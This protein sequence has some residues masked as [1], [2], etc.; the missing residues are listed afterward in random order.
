MRL[1][2]ELFTKR[3]FYGVARLTASLRRQGHSVNPKRVRR[4]MR[5]MG[6]EAIYPRPRLSANGSDHKVYP[7]L[8]KDVTVDRPDFAWA[9]DISAP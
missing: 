1:I 5:V 6:L 7:Y 9:T 2:D 3:P 4:L 8:L